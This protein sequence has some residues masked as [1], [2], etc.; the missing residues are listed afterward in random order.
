MDSFSYVWI[1][2]GTHT[3]GVVFVFSRRLLRFGEFK[4]MLIYLHTNHIF[5]MIFPCDRICDILATFLLTFLPFVDF[6]TIW[7]NVRVKNVCFSTVKFCTKT[8]RSHILYDRS[9][10][11]TKK[12]VCVF[13]T[14]WFGH[15]SNQWN[16]IERMRW[17]SNVSWNT[18]FFTIH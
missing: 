14:C 6:K 11:S 10:T 1:L 4:L 7:Q 18:T 13:S 3:I 17:I 15:C 12:I 5:M 9:T 8:N 16:K 2:I